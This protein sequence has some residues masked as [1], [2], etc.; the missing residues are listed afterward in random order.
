MYRRR[1]L[2]VNAVKS[3][4]MV[5]N[6][7][8]GLECE[9]HVDGAF[10]EHVSKLKNLGCVLYEAD[11]D[12]AESF[13]KVASRRRVAGA[14]R[15]LV[16][17]RDLQIECARILH[18]KLLIPPLMYGSETMLWKEREKSR[19]RALRMNNLRGLLGIKRMNRFPNAWIRE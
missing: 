7:E 10:L 4:V 16:K 18:K 9:V 5:M 3:K 11:T 17:A 2:K 14:I 12:G 8:K 19:I 13:R 15:S 6:G 1:G